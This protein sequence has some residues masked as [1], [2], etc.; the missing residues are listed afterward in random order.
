MLQPGDQAREHPVSAHGSV[1]W[2]HGRVEVIAASELER[3]DDL[4]EEQES[5]GQ[6]EFGCHIPTRSGSHRA[7]ANRCPDPTFGTNA[8]V[9]S[10]STAAAARRPLIVR[11]EH[12]AG[13]RPG[14]RNA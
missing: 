9:S 14:Y 1:T 4:D 7:A 6:R 8:L 3:T 12:V 11:S 5:A 13:R 10:G 2:R